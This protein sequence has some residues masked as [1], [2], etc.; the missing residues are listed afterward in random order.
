MNEEYVDQ[1][2]YATESFDD[3]K[4]ILSS[5]PGLALYNTKPNTVVSADASSFGLGVVL[6]QRQ[7]DQL[8]P[9]AYASRALTDTEQRYAQIEKEALAITW[10]CERFSDFL[11]GITF[12]V[13][14]D[15]KP[16]V[17]LL[18][19]KNLDELP[20]RIQRLRM[21]LMR[22]S[23]SISHFAGKNI[24]IADVLSRATVWSVSNT[25]QEN[26]L[27][28][29]VNMLMSTLP[30]REKTLEEIK[31]HQERDDMLRVVRRYCTEGWPDRFSLDRAFLPYQQFAGELTVRD[32]LL[33]KGSGLVI[34]KSLQTDIL[35]KLH[36][37]HQGITKCREK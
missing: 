20:V 3:I 12:H 21:R 36:V 27:D 4:R 6:L 5:P 29:Y 31:E 18:G 24:A 26:E 16:L 25:Q 19:A 11:V 30:A 23:Y 9:V 37:G 32:G 17:P 13:E 34:P 22:F 15:H 8:K 28:L 14:T 7:N 1:G 2:S 10:A 33:L 35:Q